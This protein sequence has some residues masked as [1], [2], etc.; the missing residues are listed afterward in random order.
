MPMISATM[1]IRTT[2]TAPILAGSPTE[3]PLAANE[4]TARPSSTKP[5]CRAV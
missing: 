4:P 5:V 3:S 1:P 2:P